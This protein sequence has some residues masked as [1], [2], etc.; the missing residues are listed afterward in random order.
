MK[1]YGATDQGKVRQKNQDAFLLKEKWNWVFSAVCDGIGG[2][3]A[4]EV[5]STMTIDSLN[6]QID[7]VSEFTNLAEV[8]SWVKTAVLE[9]NRTVLMA[10][11]HEDAYAGMGTTL[12]LVV[13][14]PLGTVC[15]NVGDSRIYGMNDHLVQLSTDHSYVNDLVRLGKITDEQAKVHPFRN[16]LT[17]AIGITNSLSM[18]LFDVEAYKQILLSSDG[19]HGYVEES[20]IEEVL[21]S[22]ISID[23]KVDSLIQLANDVGGYDNV[24]LIL[25]E[26]GGEA[27]V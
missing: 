26:Q 22:N 16:M 9:A 4:G 17:N 8:K 3:K 13:N 21:K 6:A 24:T 27:N 25:L 12:V 10:S 7:Q 2:G 1:F 18:D 20:K 23:K 19:L 15:V 5:A 11:I 14:G